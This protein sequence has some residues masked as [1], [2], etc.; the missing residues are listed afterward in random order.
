[1]SAAYLPGNRRHLFSLIR[2]IA[3]SLIVTTLVAVAQNRLPAGNWLNLSVAGED[4][5]GFSAGGYLRVSSTFS[6][7]G[8]Y[9]FYLNA[10]C[11]CLPA[12]FYYNQFSGGWAPKTRLIVL[13]GLFIAGTFLTGSRASVLGNVVILGVGGLLAIWFEGTKAILKVL[14]PVCLGISLLGLLQ[15]IEPELF[16]AYEARMAA[17]EDL[18]EVETRIKSDFLD[19]MYGWVEAPPTGLGY[20]LGVMSNG[21]DKISPY[22]A[23]WRGGGLWTETDRATTFFEGGWYLMIIWYG[24]RLWIIIYTLMLLFKMQT[25]ELRLMGAFAWGY[26]LVIGVMGTLAIQPPLAIWWWLAVGLIICL[27][28]FDGEPPVKETDP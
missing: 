6:F 26:I 10:L 12:V 16:A 13:V 14:V 20:G 1:M 3:L 21:S 28:Q 5:S 9:C 2:L 7:C 25:S 8:Q 4:M 22:A 15:T 11:F 23:G 24:F 17:P 19:W 27:G 18:A